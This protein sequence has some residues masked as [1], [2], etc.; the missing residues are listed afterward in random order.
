M[1]VYVLQHLNLTVTDLFMEEL[2]T[3]K[4]KA[5]DYLDVIIDMHKRFINSEHVEF[6]KMRKL[7]KGMGIRYK[8]NFNLWF[9][10]EIASDP[11]DVNQGIFI[12]TLGFC[13]LNH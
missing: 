6:K 12:S 1:I 2:E 13:Y 11:N 10:E 5:E 3:N 4:S 8:N 9:Q 7:K